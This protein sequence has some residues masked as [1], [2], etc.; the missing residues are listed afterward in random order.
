MPSEICSKILE[1]WDDS[2]AQQK[3]GWPWADGCYRWIMGT[4]KQGEIYAI[5]KTSGYTL[6]FP[7][8]EKKRKNDRWMINF[9]RLLI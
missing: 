6:N 5:L 7:E 4:G 2:G 9:R 3:Q 1:E 8:G